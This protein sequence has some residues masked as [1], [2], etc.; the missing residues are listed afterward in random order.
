MTADELDRLA[1]LEAK[2][3]KGPWFDAENKIGAGDH[4][5]AEVDFDKDADRKMLI[6]LRNAAPALIALAEW[7]ERAKPLIKQA[8]E[9]LDDTKEKHDYTF[10]TGLMRDVDELLSAYPE[11]E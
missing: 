3:T 7:A 11:G 4:G 2:A 8:F 6:E 1:K 9:Y 10:A 5:I